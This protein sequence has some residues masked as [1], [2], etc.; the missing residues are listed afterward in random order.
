M[1][2]AGTDDSRQI[3]D[4]FLATPWNN[5]EAGMML[6]NQ[7]SVFMMYEKGVSDGVFNEYVNDFLMTKVELSDSLSGYEKELKQWLEYNLRNEVF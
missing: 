1:F 6:A 2:R 5:I 4:E 3:V 7:K